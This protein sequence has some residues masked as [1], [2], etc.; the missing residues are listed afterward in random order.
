MIVQAG[1]DLANFSKQSE[2]KKNVMFDFSKLMKIIRIL[3][4]MA[5]ISYIAVVLMTWILVNQKGIVYFSAGEP[6]LL[7]KYSEWVLGFLGFFIAIYYL[8]MELSGY[9]CIIDKK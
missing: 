7:V 1:N 8:I 6:V 9:N 4:L 2:K 3:G 5:L